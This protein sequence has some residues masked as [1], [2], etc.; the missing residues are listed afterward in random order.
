MSPGLKGDKGRE[1]GRKK[2]GQGRDSKVMGE[3]GR[4]GKKR[5]VGERG[6]G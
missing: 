6:K 2:R 5:I 3:R 4:E 1:N